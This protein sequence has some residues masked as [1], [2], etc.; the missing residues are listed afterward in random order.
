MQ[1]TN[2]LA[3]P[4]GCKPPL[5]I[6]NELKRTAN[7]VGVV[8]PPTYYND[9]VVFPNAELLSEDV[10]EARVQ[11]PSSIPNESTTT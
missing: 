4:S 9:C 3:L 11:P 5:G 6:I 8:I 10:Q 7:L 1:K 2:N